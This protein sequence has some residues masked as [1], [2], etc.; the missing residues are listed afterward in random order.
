MKT[1]RIQESA[2]QLGASEAAEVLG[3]LPGAGP[4]EGISMFPDW[5]LSEKGPVPPCPPW[6]QGGWDGAW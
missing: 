2:A 5:L 4:C 1:S 3:G 6:Q